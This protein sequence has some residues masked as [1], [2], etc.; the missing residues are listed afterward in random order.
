MEYKKILVLQTAFLGDLILTTPVISGLRSRYPNSEIELLTTPDGARL[1]THDQRLN[2]VLIYDKRGKG[3]GIRGLIRI[4]KEVRNREYDLAV[5]PHRSLRSSLIPLIGRIPFRI[6]FDRSAGWFLFNMAIPYGE[7]EH[8]VVRNLRLISPLDPHFNDLQPDLHISENDET[9]TD[10]FLLKGGIDPGKSFISVAPGSIWATKRWTKSGYADL[11][12]KILKDYPVVLIGGNDDVSLAYEIIASSQMTVAIN[13]SV[14]LSAVGLTTPIQ[15]AAIIRR[16]SALVSNDSAPLHM[17]VAMQTPV[18]A[19]FGPT[20]PGFGFY[21]LGSKDR[22]VQKELACRP[23]RIHGSRKC[24]EGHFKC[25]REINP[26]DVYDC[27]MKIVK[28]EC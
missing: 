5:V 26:E 19:I 24:P 20:T 25:M 17:G 2:R 22:V 14:L 3:G 12:S 11:V 28:G 10:Q 6:G 21:P 16:S 9:W 1:F 7:K 23:C 15:S 4:L 27:V 8:E 18:C 13:G